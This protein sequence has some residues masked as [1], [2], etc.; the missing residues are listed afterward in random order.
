[1]KHF[2]EV[3]SI[4]KYFNHKVVISD[5]FL[6]CETGNVIG[7]L[8]R[9]G[10]GKSTLLK[11]IFGLEPADYKFVRIDGKPK[12]KTSELLKE[13]GYLPQHNF[14]P[15][16][17]SVKKA[18]TLAVAKA[19]CSDFFDDELLRP[20]LENKIE[21]LSAGELRYL[22]IKLILSNPSKFALL[23]E[24]YSG[25]SPLMVEKINALILESSKLKGIII[26]DHNYRNVLEISTHLILMKEGKT[27]LLKDRKELVEKGYLVEGMF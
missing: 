9:N 3:D 16:Q 19:K 5:V 2:L 27:H 23:D 13:I 26:S 10:S 22:E 6:K 20:V 11:I 7:L 15:K 4:Q 25:L 12:Q 24:P 21:E 14:I 18:I 8:G 1:M 17:F